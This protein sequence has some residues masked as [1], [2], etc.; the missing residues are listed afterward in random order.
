MA[1]AEPPA[2]PVDQKDNNVE[3][4]KEGEQRSKDIAEA[5]DAFAKKEK[6]EADDAAAV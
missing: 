3:T 6:A 1:G 4:I 5:K 2:A